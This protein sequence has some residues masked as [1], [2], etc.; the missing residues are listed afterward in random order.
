MFVSSDDFISKKKKSSK[1]QD[2]WVTYTILI[3]TVWIVNFNI[4]ISL[5]S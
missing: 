5:G 4:V 3:G 2:S 1:W